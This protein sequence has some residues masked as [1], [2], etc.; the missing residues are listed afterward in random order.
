MADKKKAANTRQKTCL[1]CFKNGAMRLTLTLHA[2]Q[3]L[4]QLTGSMNAGDAQARAVVVSGYTEGAVTPVATP[5]PTALHHLFRRQLDRVVGQ[6]GR[7]QH[8]RCPLRE[9]LRRHPCFRPPGHL[10]TRAIAALGI[11]HRPINTTSPSAMW[12]STIRI[13]VHSSRKIVLVENLVPVQVL[14]NIIKRRHQ[15]AGR[16]GTSTDASSCV[17]DSRKS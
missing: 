16:H 8:N 1:D 5:P 6:A 17:G 12:A 14:L 7:F 11:R 10:A 13:A 4:Y 3:V 2:M 9:M 15:T